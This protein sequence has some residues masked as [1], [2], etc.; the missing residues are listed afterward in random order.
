[1]LRRLGGIAGGYETNNMCII[2]Q[3]A[4]TSDFEQIGALAR[5]GDEDP[6]QKVSCVRCD[7]FGE[8]ERGRDDV[9]VQEVDVVT[10]GICWVVVEG[11]VAG[12]HGVL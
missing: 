11:Q 3:P 9:L 2:C 12:Q 10:L 8:S 7:V 4:V 5:V 6:L 1:L